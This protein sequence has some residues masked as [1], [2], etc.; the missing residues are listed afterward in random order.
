MTTQVTVTLRDDVYHNAEQLAQSTGREVA[1]V[2]AA[3]F[4][5]S[6]PVV[7]PLELSKPIEELT[8]NEVLTLADSRMD[9]AQ[10][11]RMS[12]LLEKQQ[13]DHLDAVEQHE[14]S[15]LLYVYQEGSLL[16]AQAL[17]EAVKRGLR[18]APTR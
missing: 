1:D 7:A 17:V 8:D 15:M 9:T 18:T 5:A 14:L 4:Q 11:T 10:N 13:S 16:K 2:V 3:M 12:A 6:F